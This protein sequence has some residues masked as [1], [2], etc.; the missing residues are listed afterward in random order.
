MVI[1]A[2]SRKNVVA[3]VLLHDNRA[4]A[5]MELASKGKTK[6]FWLEDG[7]LYAKG[8]RIYVPDWG[9]LRRDIL[10][11]CHDSRLS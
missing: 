1:D 9:H 3:P 5:L 6:K 7:V 8:Q 4:Q 11:E 10:K 2:L